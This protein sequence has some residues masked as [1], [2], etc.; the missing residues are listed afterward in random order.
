MVEDI[1]GI[2]KVAENLPE[3]TSDYYI[4][5]PLRKVKSSLNNLCRLGLCTIKTEKFVQI[6]STNPRAI[7][8]LYLTYLG[9]DF[10]SKVTS[11]NIQINE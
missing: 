11:P 3:L 10:L 4:K 1:T 5:Q 7:N 8:K 9:E 2:G 6:T